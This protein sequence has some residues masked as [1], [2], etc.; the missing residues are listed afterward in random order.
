MEAISSSSISLFFI[1]GRELP[2]LNEMQSQT[3]NTLNTQLNQFECGVI[4]KWQSITKL[5]PSIYRKNFTMFV[6]KNDALMSWCLYWGLLYTFLFSAFS[7]KTLI[8][9]HI[10]EE[11]NQPTL[12][13]FQLWII[14]WIKHND[15][16]LNFVIAQRRVHNP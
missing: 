1:G 11:F 5:R 16:G 13:L 15:V 9:I 2:I 14:K 7:R 10:S 6:H 12:C 8:R 4:Y 3:S